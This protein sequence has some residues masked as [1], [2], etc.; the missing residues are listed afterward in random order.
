ML[1]KGESGADWP[2][3][4]GGQGAK[5]RPAPAF[6]LVQPADG[7]QSPLMLQPARFYRPCRICMK[8][9]FCYPRTDCNYITD[10]EAYLAQNLTATRGCCQPCR[11]QRANEALKGGEALCRLRQV[12][13][14]HAI[15]MTKTVPNQAQMAKCPSWKGR[16]MTWS[17]GNF[18]MF[19]KAYVYEKYHGLINVGQLTLKPAAM[20]A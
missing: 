14:H 20:S 13:E 10:N 15:I 16:S 2:G 11:S 12:Q 1:A 18:E 9:S 3:G 6:L 17:C 7:S 4:Q 8:I 19:L 5:D